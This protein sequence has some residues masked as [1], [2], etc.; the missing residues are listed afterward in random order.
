M[1][2]RINPTL[3]DKLVADL[4]LDG[5]RVDGEDVTGLDRSLRFYTVPRLE[6]F[7]EAALRATVLRELNW[8]LNTTSFGSA[9]DLSQAPEVATSALNYGLGDLTG[10]LLTRQAVHARARDMR[11]AILRYE[12]R[13]D[14]RSL[15]VEAD[16]TRERANSVGF[17]IRGDVTTAVRAL[18]VEFRTDVEID[19]GAVTLWGE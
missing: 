14:R 4:E 16:L 10:K 18:P 5:L 7:N 13:V 8:L 17:T 19:T 9:Q 3:F 12:P 11:E 1:S 2:S 6:R 15:D